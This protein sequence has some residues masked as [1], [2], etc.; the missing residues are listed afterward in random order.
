ME[1][2]L[3][4]SPH[5]EKNCS[6]ALKQFLYTGYITNFDWGC[7]D[8]EHTGWAIIEANDAKEAMMVVPP[9]PFSPPFR[10]GGYGGFGLLYQ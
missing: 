10:K 5:T 7:A 1:R 6:D 3:I 4:I 2:F 8:G 9:T